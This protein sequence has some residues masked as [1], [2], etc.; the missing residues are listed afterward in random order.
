MIISIG[1]TKRDIEV[2]T[3]YN[4]NLYTKENCVAFMYKSGKKV[5]VDRGRIINGKIQPVFNHGSM[6]SPICFADEVDTNNTTKN[7][8]IDKR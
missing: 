6:M 7:W 3:A 1:N 5:H 4:G 2:E 8:S